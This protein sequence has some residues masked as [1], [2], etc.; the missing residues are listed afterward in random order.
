MSVAT[1]IAE[2]FGPGAS[3]AGVVLMGYGVGDYVPPP[4]PAP[5]AV[6]V[7]GGLP[8]PKRRTA[9][10]NGKT[11]IGTEDDIEAL[12][13]SILNSEDE[14]EV[15]PKRVNKKKAVPVE[16]DEHEAPYVEMLPMAVLKPRFRA[17]IKESRI[18]DDPW[19]THLLRQIM[20]E[21]EEEEDLEIIL[22]GLH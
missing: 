14:P 19:M 4:D 20:A 22:M 12:V 7:G 13:R 10:I 21:Y 9:V 15:K 8:A 1:V 6:T 17:L 5:S 16:I 18:N 11:Y 2:G 3:V